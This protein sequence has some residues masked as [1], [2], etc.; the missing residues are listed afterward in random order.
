MY[1][2]NLKRIKGSGEG[3][4]INFPTINSTMDKLPDGL[5]IGLYAACVNYEMKALTLISKVKVGGFRFETHVFNGC[6]LDDN[7]TYNLFL[8]KKLRNHKNFKDREKQISIDKNLVNLFFK[9]VNTCYECEYL[10]QHEYGYSNY[11]VTD[12]DYSCLLEI[13]SD[14]SRPTYNSAYSYANKCNG[15]VKG[16]GWV[17]DVDG[18]EAKPSEEYLK[19]IKRTHNINNILS[20]EI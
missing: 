8:F 3:T 18:V 5:T 9:E 1:D 17:F 7:T 15:F 6:Y 10:C 13:F 11:T 16:E 12:V 14:I 4:K 19:Q 20:D 2:I